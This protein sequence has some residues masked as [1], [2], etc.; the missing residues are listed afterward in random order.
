MIVFGP[1]TCGSSLNEL[2]GT[3]SISV[4]Q[5]GN[6]Y[7]SDSSQN[8]VVR[9]SQYASSATLIAGISG[10]SGSQLNQLNNPSGIFLDSTNTLYVADQ[11]N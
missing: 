3:N 9:F 11:N 5:N 7:Y 4:D 1:T 6:I 2:C 10:S 8:R